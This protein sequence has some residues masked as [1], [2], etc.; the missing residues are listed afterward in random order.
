MEIFNLQNLTFCFPEQT[1]PVLRDISFSVTPGEFVVLAGPSGCGKSTLLR[2]LKTVLAPHGELTGQLQFM[3][4][5][6]AETDLAVQTAR[7]GF[8]QQSPENQIVT[9]KV[10]HEL[11]LRPG[12]SGLRYADDSQPCGGDGQLF[13]HSDLVL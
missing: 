3:G 5:P 6:L 11:A 12:E 2:Q 4:K 1:E 9:D 10:W 8:V 13:W 7:I